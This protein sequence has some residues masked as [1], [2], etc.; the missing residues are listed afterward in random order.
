LKKKEAARFKR[1][2]HILAFNCA[3]YQ[4]LN[5][6]KPPCTITANQNR[7]VIYATTPRGPEV[8][9][10]RRS[11]CINQRHDALNSA[12]MRAQSWRPSLWMEQ[13]QAP[14][15]PFAPGAVTVPREI[16]KQLA[17]TDGNHRRRLAKKAR[18]E[19]ARKMGKTKKP[20][21]K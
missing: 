19:L 12:A 6:K 16:K 15:R 14:Y 3:Y 8:W 9:H 20:K 10:E 4:A 13:S 7:A 11:E 21:N 1:K 2:L 18:A 17:K 5:K